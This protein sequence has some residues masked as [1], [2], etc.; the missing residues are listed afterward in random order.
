MVP[1]MIR[2]LPWAVLVVLLVSCG[3]DDDDEPNAP[4]GGTTAIGGSAPTG[5]GNSAGGTTATGGA[6]VAP[7]GDLGVGDVSC[8][9][10]ALVCPG[11]QVCCDIL[12]QAETCVASFAACG[13]EATTDDCAT[14]ACDGPE[15]CPGA[16]C[17]GAMNYDGMNELAG[18]SCKATCEPPNEV[19]VC[20]TD[21]DCTSGG[22]CMSSSSGYLRCF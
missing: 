17:C 3:G 2:N 4:A 14:F 9:P 8:G 10:G 18:S 16:V 15:D 5:G 12:F 19:I 1:P 7:F 22:S 21:A 11:G 6:A 13:C 20:S